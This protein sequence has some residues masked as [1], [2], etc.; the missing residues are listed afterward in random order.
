MLRLIH[1]QVVQGALLVDDIDDGLPN[2]PTHRIGSV[3]DPNAYPRDGYANDPKQGCYVP[4]V[5]ITDPTIA[6]YIDLD[7]TERVILSAGKGKIW[8]LQRTTPYP[9]I[10][11][12]S[13]VEGD[14]VAPV[15]TG[16]TLDSPALGDA[17]INGTTFLSVVPEITSVHLYGAGVGDVTLTKAQIEAVPPGA[18]GALQIIIDSTLITGFTSGDFVVVHANAQDSNVFTAP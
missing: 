5:K 12:V 6:G 7:E 13:F 14:V 4:R 11:V 15:I 9:L 8:G 2:K 16:V 17:T 10:T 3:G 1:T 18:V